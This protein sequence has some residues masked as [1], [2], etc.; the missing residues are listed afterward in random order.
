MSEQGGTQTDADLSEFLAQGCGRPL[1]DGGQALVHELVAERARIHPHAPALHCGGRSIEYGTLLAWS[2]RIAARVIAGGASRGGHVGVFAE[3]SPAMVAVALGILR[4]GAAYV[5][6]DPALPDLRLAQ[7]VADARLDAVLATATVR[8]RLAGLG[9]HVALD[10]ADDPEDELAEPPAPATE[11]A[12]AA[13]PAYL[14]Y[15]SGSTG[16]PKGVVVEHRQLA[17]STEARRLVY[18]GAPTFLLLSPLSFDSSVAGLWG[19]LTAGGRLVVAQASEVRDP[20]RLVELIDAHQVTHTLCVPSLYSVLL[21]AAER[22]GVGRLRSLE[23]V[24]LGGEA[25][26]AELLSRHFALQPGPCALVNEYG[27]TE[28]T[29]WASYRRYNATGPVSIGGPV[30][31]ARL[32]VLDDRLRPVPQGAEGELVIGGAGVARGYFGREEAT[33]DAFVED[34][35]AVE[36]GARMYRT[37]D[38]ARWRDDATLEFL[39]RRDHQVKIRGHRV[40][41]GAVETALAA[42]PGVRDAVAVTDSAR[43]RLTAF[44]VPTTNHLL[45]ESMRSELADRLPPVQVPAAIHVVDALPRTVN[46]KVDRAALRAIADGDRPAPARAG[47]APLASA[48]SAPAGGDRAVTLVTA[49]WAEVLKRSDIPTRVN[50]FDLG[51]HS[52]G[53]FELQDALERH[54]GFRPSIVAL[55][56]DTTVSAQAGLV[57]EHVSEVPEPPPAQHSAATWLACAVR[58]PSARRRLICFPHAGGSASFFRDWGHHLTDSEVHAVRYPGR[59]ER[60]DEPPPTDLRALAH[61]IATA[62]EPLAGLPLALFGHS[63]GAVVALETARALEARGLPVAHLVASGSRDGEPNGHGADEID[64]GDGSAV[65][66][67][68]VELGGTDPELASDPAF[69]ELVLP[70]VLADGQMFHAY[71][72]ER[73][74][75]LGCPV[76]TIVGDRDTDADVR[77]WSDLTGGVHREHVVSGDH[78]YLVSDPPHGLLRDCL[79]TTSTGG[80]WCA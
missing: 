16:E 24:I 51:G 42:L 60:I 14:V 45:P 74:P 41:L 26:P 3:P 69:R 18:P 62:V 28:A 59:G 25:M 21:D 58:Q 1:P 38:R 19:T 20:E 54:T 12:T 80:R 23:T 72:L 35:Y 77:P 33:A 31:G 67:R 36:G 78:F 22:L 71:R 40:E 44:A 56:R 49:A 6:L 15:T 5:P 2:D 37:G 48:F 29:V 13:D 46:G 34:P 4:A 76:T 50:F 43:T 27:P 53:M 55:F 64:A 61:E 52:I 39:G 75:R 10:L 79:D 57:R 70:Y 63:M 8:G 17:A 32:Y 66:A 65:A 11:P 9:P 30:P 73:E 47:A 68:L 7:L